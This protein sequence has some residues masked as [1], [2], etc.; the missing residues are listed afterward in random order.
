M[1]KISAILLSFSLLCFLSMPVSSPAWAGDQSI[2]T[3]ESKQLIGSFYN[4]YVFGNEEL[5]NT[6]A[7]NWGTQKFL[8][9][10]KQDYEYDCE[11]DD[12]YAAYA[13][14][15]G[16]QDGDGTSSVTSI[17]PRSNGW[18]RVSYRDMGWKGVTDVKVV[19][20]NG[21]PKLDDYKFVSSNVK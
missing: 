4:Q 15:T 17:T 6:N 20:V 12:C 18:Y 13:L 11:S 16:A 3:Q 10:L 5:D 2:S 7:S 21:I 8:K 9:K 14:R 1:K 19:G